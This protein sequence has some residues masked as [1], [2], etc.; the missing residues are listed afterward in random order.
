MIFKKDNFV[1]G[2]ALGLIAPL[3]GFMVFK[4]VKFN[5][6][7]LTEMLQ[8]MK[9]NPNLI[10][11]SISMSLLANAILFTIYI[12]GNRDKTAKGV[13]A[14]TCIYAAIAMAFKYL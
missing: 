1:F 8:W 12:N 2:M 13:F 11:V 6:L 9:F 10:T 7:T 4:L 3:I 5:G 14:L